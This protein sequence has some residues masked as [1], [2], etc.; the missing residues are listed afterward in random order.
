MD[1]MESLAAKRPF[2]FGFV[3]TFVFILLILTSSIVASA[4][5]LG[6]TKGWYIGSTIGRLVS[7]SIP[8]TVLVRLGWTGPAGFVRLGSPGIWLIMLFALTY[9]IAGSLYAFTGNFDIGF[10]DPLLTSV[11]AL[12]I[13]AHAFLEEVAFRGLVLHG[14]VRAW[15]GADRGFLMSLL[16]SSFYFG[17]MHL[18]Y[19]LGEPA[20]VVLLRFVAAFL[21]G[22]FFGA[23][24]M[25]GGSIY[26]AA[27]FHGVLNVAGYLNLTSNAVEGAYTSWLLISLS[28]IP[29]ALY[30]FYLIRNLPQRSAQRDLA[31][32]KNF[33]SF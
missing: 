33:P 2:A 10:S 21:L 30:G 32:S 15:V 27:F 7:I 8:L 28:Y 22:I 31:F 3:V 18:I 17:G 9:A 26:P 19:I 23:L 11:A 12:F 25:R 1:R 6:E 13:L 24:V 20:P 5:W 14:F 4:N 16:V 29:L